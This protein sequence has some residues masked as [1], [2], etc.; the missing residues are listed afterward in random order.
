MPTVAVIFKF[1]SGVWHLVNGEYFIHNDQ[2]WKRCNGRVWSNWDTSANSTSSIFL[3]KAFLK[4]ILGL[5]LPIYR[6]YMA[7]S[8]IL[9]GSGFCSKWS[10]EL[11]KH[12]CI[13]CWI[14]DR[15]NRLILK[16]AGAELCQAQQSHSDLQYLQVIKYTVISDRSGAWL[17]MVQCIT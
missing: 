1:L 5:F 17:V 7:W 3:E 15:T 9:G 11:F 13:I 14:L 16:E 2:N 8:E 4:L 10:G 6:G 12:L